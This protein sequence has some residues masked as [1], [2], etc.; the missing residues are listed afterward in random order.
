MSREVFA[1][2]DDLTGALEVGAHF[3]ARGWHSIVST[4]TAAEQAGE[5]PGV[6][7]LDTETRHTSPS[8]A[9]GVIHRATR[10]VPRDSKFFKKTDSTLRGN[11]GSELEALSSA[12]GGVTIVY[13]PA[14]PEL[15]R[16][17]RDGVL[18]VDGKPLHQTEFA[19]DPLNPATES[20]IP[21]VLSAQTGLPVHAVSPRELKL[22]DAPCILVCDGVREEDIALA[23][24]FVTRNENLVGAGPSALAREL[25]RDL[26]QPGPAPPLPLVQTCVVVNGSLHPRSLAQC[27]AARESL[28]EGWALLELQTDATGGESSHPER[29]G[30]AVWE[31]IRRRDPDAILVSGGD[32][33]HGILR[34]LGEPPLFSIGEAAPGVPVSRIRAADLP[35]SWGRTRDLYVV[36]KAGGFGD[37]RIVLDLQARL[38]NRNRGNTP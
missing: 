28:R 21:A 10:T 30:N 2:A 16:T 20:S 19:R 29:A 14:Y 7:V 8:K 37:D 9:A 27:R 12:L 25:A 24:R 23:A 33:A 15:G 11:I 1:L 17:V 26:E 32:T 18:Y 35:S 3:A 5:G 34:T 22:P 6:F 38:Q 13:V 4:R 36:S 31:E